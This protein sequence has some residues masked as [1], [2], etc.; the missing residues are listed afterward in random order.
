MCA[1]MLRKSPAATHGGQRARVVSLPVHESRCGALRT[2]FAYRCDDAG[3]TALVMTLT[4]AM[5]TA[6]PPLLQVAH[7]L[8][9]LTD[10]TKRG[11]T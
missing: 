2:W 4:A 9:S 11:M 5:A 3:Q 6:I 8:R 10:T 7:R 1:L